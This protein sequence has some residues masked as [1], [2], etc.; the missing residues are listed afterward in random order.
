[1][2]AARTTWPAGVTTT[3]RYEKRRAAI[4]TVTGSPA[5]AGMM[6]RNH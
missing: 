3:I 6:P 2:V 1:M 4:R 5:T